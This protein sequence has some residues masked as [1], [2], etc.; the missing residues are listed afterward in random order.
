MPSILGPK[1]RLVLRRWVQGAIGLVLTAVPGVAQTQL[2]LDRFGSATSDAALAGASDGSGGLFVAGYVGTNIDTNPPWGESS[3]QA[4][5]ARYDGA[6]NRLWMRRLG[7][8]EN[9]SAGVAV[10]DGA[11]GVFLAGDA[12]RDVWPPSTLWAG[13]FDDEG[14]TTWIQ[15]LNVGTH[16]QSGA[17]DS[18]GGLLLCGFGPGGGPMGAW[19]ARL[20]AN[21]SL[22]WN[23]Q[24]PFQAAFGEAADAVVS[25]G[26]GGA[27]ACGSLFHANFQDDAWLARLD[28]TGQVLW[29]VVFATFGG[30]YARALLP[31]STGGVYV[32]GSTAGPLGGAWQGSSDAWLAQFDGTGTQLWIKQ[33][34]TVAAEGIWRLAADGMGGLLAAVKVNNSANLVRFNAV[35]TL[36]STQVVMKSSNTAIGLLVSDSIGG[37]FIG[38]A[39]GPLVDGGLPGQTD[40]W[41][42]RNN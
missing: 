31:D 12:I 36:T 1:R 15:G 16:V 19:V 27:F 8:S 28:A 40:I 30:D 20:D 9:S 26:Q 14:N 2:W 11:G 6:G 10:S 39:G 17:A 13:H 41:V 35:G 38:G 22:M 5:L 42:A 21:G 24:L 33:H 4:L 37:A 3:T 7:T 32:G 25:D 18:S 34:G 29:S 23:T